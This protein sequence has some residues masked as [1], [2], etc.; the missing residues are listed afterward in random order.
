MD[1]EGDDLVEGVE[2]ERVAPSC[3]S[4]AELVIK[5]SWV[6]ESYRKK[7]QTHDPRLPRVK[8]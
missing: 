4:S 8:P 7:T 5:V 3:D 2:N 1:C 6:G